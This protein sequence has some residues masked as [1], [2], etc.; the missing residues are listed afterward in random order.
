MNNQNFN[1]L[2]LQN[3]FS[4]FLTKELSSWKYLLNDLL[5][6]NGVQLDLICGDDDGDTARQILELLLEGKTPAEVTESI[7]NRLSASKEDIMRAIGGDLNYLDLDIIRLSYDCV[8]EREQKVANA[9][10]KLIAAASDI[11]EYVDLLTTIPGVNELSAV[12]ILAE[13]GTD[14]SQF[15]S[16]TRISSWAGFSPG[17]K[18]S[19]NTRMSGKTQKR[20]YWTKTIMCE[21]AEAA[22]KTD[23]QLRKKFEMLNSRIG[24][25]KAIIGLAHKMMKIV[26]VVIKNKDVYKDY[27]FDYQV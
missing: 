4:M 23:S 20:H 21:C 15:G 14:M 9:N 2:K 18:K 25:R 3:R 8:L 10:K 6:E 17:K 24:Y 13:I 12:K 22:A 27:K 19:A 1:K 16:P 26:F 11:K 5:V 7:G